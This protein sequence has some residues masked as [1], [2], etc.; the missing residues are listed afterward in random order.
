MV[1]VED[2]NKETRIKANN[3]MKNS[4][5]ENTDE[6][7]LKVVDKVVDKPKIADTNNIN[8]N[9]LINSD[10]IQKEELEL[11]AEAEVKKQEDEKLRETLKK[12]KQEQI[13]ILKETK[14]ILQDIK[15]Q[16]KEWEKAVHQQAE[17]DKKGASSLNQTNN[18]KQKKVKDH[19]LGALTKGMTLKNQSSDKLPNSEKKLLPIPIVHQMINQTQQGN[20]SDGKSNLTN[21]HER[22]KRDAEIDI[23]KTSDVE[24]TTTQVSDTDEKDSQSNICIKKNNLSKDDGEP[25]FNVD[26]LIETAS[27]SLQQEFTNKP[28]A[29]LRIQKSTAIKKRDLKAFSVDKK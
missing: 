4:E 20:I 15:E 8:G 14:E 23:N 29:F 26:N 25:Q 28:E 7:K 13:K 19:I 5:G 2:V 10:A 11:A 12:Y 24:H 21:Q 27:L 16:K 6:S 17:G 3:K 9:N 1:K 18:D 22:E